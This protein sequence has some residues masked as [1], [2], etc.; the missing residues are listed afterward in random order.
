MNTINLYF[1]I[2]SVIYV[3]ALF[4]RPLPRI[5]FTVSEALA[6]LAVIVYFLQNNKPNLNTLDYKHLLI[7]LIIGLAI[8]HVLFLFGIFLIN[9]NKHLFYLF[10]F[11]W[12]MIL[13]KN[14]FRNFSYHTAVALY[15]E[16]VWRVGIIG[17]WQ[18]SPFGV[19]ISTVLFIVKHSDSI[20]YSNALR[21]DFRI[22]SFIS[23][24]LF[25][26]TGSY[27]LLV[28]LHLMRNVDILYLNSIR[29]T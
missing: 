21:W 1:P 22:Y 25:Y 14:F 20:F 17:I 27:V 7:E 2:F 19:I 26:F 4:K 10:L 6:F 24:L 3:A 8:G 16:I 15:E 9:K 11:P 18:Y 5:L 29:K 23:C 28:G 12:K 13:E